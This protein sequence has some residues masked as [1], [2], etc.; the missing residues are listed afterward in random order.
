MDPGA[1]GKELPADNPLETAISRK[2]APTNE[3]TMLAG[4]RMETKNSKK[5]ALAKELRTLVD[6]LLKGSWKNGKGPIVPTPG[7]L[8]ATYVRL[9]TEFEEIVAVEK[10]YSPGK[11]MAPIEDEEMPPGGLGSPSELHK[12]KI[13]AY[14]SCGF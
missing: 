11:V 5:Q 10:K 12:V 9:K 13:M 2:R 14:H 4:Q 3:L 8:I 7:T 6:E 1:L